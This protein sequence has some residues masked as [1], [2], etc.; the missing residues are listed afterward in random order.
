MFIRIRHGHCILSLFYL[1]VHLI[2]V[3]SVFCSR[4]IPEI[5]NL[6][7]R[8]R[9]GK[10]YSAVTYSIC[11]SFYHPLQVSDIVTMKTSIF[12]S[13]ASLQAG[14][15]ETLTCDLSFPVPANRGETVTDTPVHTGTAMICYERLAMVRNLTLNLF[16]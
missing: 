12:Y 15:S 16:I 3:L 8:F 2:V 1:A 9:S 5:R 6:S 14:R 10:H 13:A 11:A 4:C 7:H